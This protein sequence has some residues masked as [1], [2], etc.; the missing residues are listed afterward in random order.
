[1]DKNNSIDTEGEH[2]TDSYWVLGSH[3][4]LCRENHMSLQG[5]WWSDNQGNKFYYLYCDN[6]KDPG[7]PFDEVLE[8]YPEN[9]KLI[10][11]LKTQSFTLPIPWNNALKFL[12]KSIT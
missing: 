9:S 12:N 3:C 4:P 8:A 6:I 1:M 2:Q 11:E 5:K 7:I 10:Q